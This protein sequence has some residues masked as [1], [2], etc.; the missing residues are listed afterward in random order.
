M[1]KGILFILLLAILVFAYLRY[2]EYSSLY[3][4]T[5]DFGGTPDDIG[6]K[7]EDV[8][9]ETKDGVRI[10]AWF[11]PSTGSRFVILFLHG[12]GGNISNRLDKIA[13]LNEIGCDVFIIDYRGYGRSSSR[14]SEEGFYIDAESSYDHLINKKNIPSQKIVLYGESLGGAVAVDLATKREIRAIITEATFSN[15]KDAARVIYPW[16]PT[17]LIAAEF[18]SLS[19]IK[20]INVPKLIMHSR[21]DDLIPFSQSIKLYNAA[22][23]PK[24]HIVLGGDHNDSYISSKDLYSQSIKNFLNTL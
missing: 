10:N 7:Y 2:F 20:D 11:V 16:L 13:I 4:P 21:S 19:K 17:Y 6:L 15:V 8:Y 14:P 3:Y 1:I 12:N 23:N 9:F 24:Q 18:D 22:P 5:R